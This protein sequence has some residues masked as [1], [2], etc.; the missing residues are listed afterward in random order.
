M[1]CRDERLNSDQIAIF[2]HER[3][4]RVTR[5]N[6]GF[7]RT[8]KHTCVGASYLSHVSCINGVLSSTTA[9]S[10]GTCPGATH[11]HTT[12]RACRSRWFRCLPAPGGRGT[13]WTQ[14]THWAEQI[15]SLPL[16][17]RTPLKNRDKMY[18][19]RPGPRTSSAHHD[20]VRHSSELRGHPMSWA[21]VNVPAEPRILFRR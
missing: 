3:A 10:Y 12:A 20:I 2:R 7:A 13:D 16:P 8:K 4:G 6:P 9:A 21:Q 1:G 15:F 14:N 19:L 17:S 11:A 18:V 5:T